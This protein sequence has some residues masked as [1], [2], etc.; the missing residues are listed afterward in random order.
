MSRDIRYNPYGYAIY[1]EPSSHRIS[2]AEL[3]ARLTSVEAL[4]NVR[5]APPVE[6]VNLNLL[7]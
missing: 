7:P 2:M 1:S 6:T 4:L 5:R 3:D